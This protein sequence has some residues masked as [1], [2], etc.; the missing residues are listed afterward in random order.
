MKDP[1][2]DGGGWKSEEEADRQ[3]ASGLIT[4]S[5]FFSVGAV[6]SLVLLVVDRSLSVIWLAALGLSSL[7]AAYFWKR[8]LRADRWKSIRR[9]EKR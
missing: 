3:I 1:I 7:F 8:T 4:L 9:R 2:I 5:V 6:A